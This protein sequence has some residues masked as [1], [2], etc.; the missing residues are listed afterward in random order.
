MVIRVQHETAKIYQFPVKA[1]PTAVG[2]RAKLNLTPDIGTSIAT[3]AFD[4]WY[5]E[6]AIVE[7]DETRKQ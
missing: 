2:Q 3:A 5:H 7:S 1:R 4:S 6:A